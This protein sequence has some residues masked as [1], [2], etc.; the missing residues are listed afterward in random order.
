MTTT[1]ISP[2]LMAELTAAL[3]ATPP[4]CECRHNE[5]RGQVRCTERASHR[6]TVV[7]VAPNC[8]CAAGVHLLCQLCLGSW[9]RS[10]RSNGVK[11]RVRPL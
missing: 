5:P 8:T 10:A 4:R 6:V 7:C 9:K 2:D 11:L 1:T 3:A